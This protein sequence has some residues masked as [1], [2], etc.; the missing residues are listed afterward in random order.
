MTLVDAFTKFAQ[1]IPIEGKTAIN[2][3]NALI[4]YFSSFGIPEKLILDNAREFNNET[5]K[6]I[7]NLH[8]IKIHFTTPYHHDSNGIVE[9]FHSSIIEL[10][11]IPLETYPNDKLNIMTMQ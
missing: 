7:L 2:V 11:R 1:A 9:R 4:K 6:E 3:S 5:V 8:K 10:L